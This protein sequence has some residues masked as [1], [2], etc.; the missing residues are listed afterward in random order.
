MISIPFR[1]TEHLGGFAEYSGLLKLKASSFVIEMQS[2]DTILG[3]LKSK[4]KVVEIPFEIIE[5]I[6]LKKSL[7]H[8]KIIIRVS[9]LKLLSQVPSSELGALTLIVKKKLSQEATELVSTAQ[10]TLSDLKLKRME[11]HFPL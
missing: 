3:I 7:F 8:S 10:M 5:D 4:I 6:A 11:E 9:D 1:L 2:R